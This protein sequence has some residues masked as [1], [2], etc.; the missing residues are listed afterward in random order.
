LIGPV[1]AEIDASGATSGW[2]VTGDSAGLHAVA[3]ITVA[4]KAMYMDL[5]FI[6]LSFG[7]CSGITIVV[8]T[9]QKTY[10]VTNGLT[11]SA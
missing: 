8:T 7:C 3:A 6:D 2:I 5:S 9:Y 1:S 11:I 10:G 4:A